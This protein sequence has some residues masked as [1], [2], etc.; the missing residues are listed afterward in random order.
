VTVTPVPDIPLPGFGHFRVSAAI[1]IL[2]IVI[3]VIVHY[4]VR[5]G[6]A[7]RVRG[8]L[9]RHARASVGEPGCLGFLAFQDAEDPE[10]FALYE[11]YEDAAAFE[12]HRRTEHFR[13]NIEQTIDPMLA[14][15]EW[16]VY[17]PPIEED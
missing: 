2:S 8:V 17:G 7:E 11:A 5:P 3:T 6:T 10:R 13:V 12:A 4:R 9:A 14:E 1:R 16:R 15:R